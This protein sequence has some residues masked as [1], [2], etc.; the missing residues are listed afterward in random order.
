MR[1]RSFLTGAGRFYPI[2]RTFFYA[3]RKMPRC[4]YAISRWRSA[5]PSGRFGTLSPTLKKPVTSNV[6]E[7]VVGI[8]IRSMN[9]YD[10]GILLNTTRQSRISFGLFRTS[11]KT[12]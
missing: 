11:R 7:L 8:P 3:W 12:E 6:S 5:L 2:T 10:C 1:A 4:E 9:R